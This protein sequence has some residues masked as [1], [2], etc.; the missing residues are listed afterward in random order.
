MIAIQILDVLNLPMILFLGLMTSYEDFKFRKIRNK[1]IT[2]SFLYSF[3]TFIGFSMFLVSR[4]NEINPLYVKVFFLNMFISLGFGIL[5]W[6]SNLWSAGDAKLFLAY[7]VLIPLST[8]KWGETGA[9]PGYIIL[10]NT[11]TPIFIFYLFKILFSVRPKIFI[12]EL[13]NTLSP[14]RILN[15]A[16][17]IFGFQ[18]MN[19]IIFKIFS[20]EANLVI[21]TL[22][23]L[24]FMVLFTDILKVNML[25]FSGV[26]SIYRIIFEFTEVMNINFFF[27]LFRQLLALMIFRYFLISLGGKVLR[28]GIFIEDLKQGMCLEKDIIKT[29][30]KYSHKEDVSIS[31]L[32][33]L[34]SSFRKNE[35]IFSDFRCLAKKDITKIKRLH[36]SGKLKEHAVYIYE[37]IFFA[38]FLFIGALLTLLFRGNFLIAIRA[39]AESFI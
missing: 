37:K 35:S 12:D 21:S 22:F 10:I 18:A 11:F 2:L 25:F 23:L 20:I 38:L 19:T 33:S 17:F 13:K 7:S 30:G 36:S 24:L 14:I 34:F 31:V 5:L 3:A 9:F 15:F 39:I 32:N 6:I 28:K 8:Y 16:L 29:K 1:W 4:G 26:L 27:S